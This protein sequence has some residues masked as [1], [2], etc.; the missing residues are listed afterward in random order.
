MNKMKEILELNTPTVKN[1]KPLVY[2]DQNILDIFHK[3]IPEEHSVSILF[4]ED[5]QVVYSNTTLAEIHKAGVNGKNPKYTNNFLDVLTRLNAQHISLMMEDGHIINKIYRSFQS[6]VAHYKLFLENIEYDEFIA[7][8]QKTS[9]ALFG[10]VDDYETLKAEQKKVMQ[11]LQT[12]LKA[13]IELLKEGNDRNLDI[14]FFIKDYEQKIIDLDSQIEGFNESVDELLDNIRNHTTEKSG[15]QALRECLNIDINILK[16]I[17]SP[18]TLNKISEYLQR[19]NEENEVSIDL[20]FSFDNSHITLDRE[21]YIFEKVNQIYAVLNLIGYHE[22]EKLHKEDKH[23]RALRDMHHASY[24]CFCEY[25]FTNDERLIKKMQA[26]YEY[27]NIATQ[28]C[29]LN[30]N[31][32]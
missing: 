30:L 22:D 2:F 29:S 24:A 32:E 11:D 6:P 31:F 26:A 8:M 13:Q 14:E 17:G 9:L 19:I 23:L 10:G 27:L 4:T 12:Y 5:F 20:I 18:D 1:E 25:F 21:P 15:H 3:H 16:N 7:P 28:I